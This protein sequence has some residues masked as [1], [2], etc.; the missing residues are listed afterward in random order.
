MGWPWVLSKTRRQ[1]W[2][3][4]LSCQVCGYIMLLK[5]YYFCIRW[6]DTSSLQCTDSWF[7]LLTFNWCVC[8][9]FLCY[10]RGAMCRH[11]AVRWLWSL[12]LSGCL[13]VGGMIGGP[14]EL[15]GPFT[16]SSLTDSMSKCLI[17]HKQPEQSRLGA[18]PSSL[19]GRH[20]SAYLALSYSVTPKWTKTV[21]Q[22]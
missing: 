14:W 7:F 1:N 11:L 6:N 21:K 22:D 8:V 9:L 18:S 20:S 5:Y 15:H 13:C 4:C 3:L 10:S 2:A 19:I 17:R 16:S 12:S